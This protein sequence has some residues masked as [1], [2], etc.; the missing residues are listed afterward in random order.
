MPGLRLIA[1]NRMEDLVERLAEILATPLASPLEKEI[2]LVQS[3]GMERWVSMELARRHGVCANIRF[4][5]PNAFL[6]ET[7]SRVLGADQDSSFYE[8][9]AMTWMIMK[10]LRS[11]VGPPQFES[12]GNYL[13]ND[14][15]QLKR[16]QLARRI[17][18]LFDQYL[19]FRPEMT[20]AWENGREDHWQALLWREL[21]RGAN[22]VHRAALKRAFLEK[23]RDSSTEMEGFPD[24]LCIFG[25]SALPP[26][27]LEVIT[28]LSRFIRVNLFLM[29]PCQEYWG[30]IASDREIGRV[31]KKSEAKGLTPEQLHLE[32][33]NS[34]LAS[35]GTLGRDF[36]SLI[37]DK[38]WEEEEFF[39]DPGE[40]SLLACIQ[41]DILHL[42]EREPGS[43]TPISPEDRSIVVHSCHSPMREIEVL[44]DNLLALF[45]KQPELNPRDILV[46]TPDISSYAPF[47]QAVFDAPEKPS[48]RIPFSLADRSIRGESKILAV[49]LAILALSG[50]RFGASRVLAILEADAVRRKFGFSE[51]DLDAVRRWVDDT[52]IRWGIDGAHRAALGFPEFPENSWRA[53]L[54]R[55][56][57]GFA[58]P[59]GGGKLFRS[60]LPYDN[61]EGA[62]TVILGKF[63]E[64]TSR[65]FS[66][67]NE[68]E[69]PRTLAQWSATLT[70]LLDDF[71]QPEP[72][73][74]REVLML[75]QSLADLAARQELSGFDETVTLGVIRSHL[76]QQLESGS[77][78]PGF[79]TGG[80]TFCAM[81][82]MRAIPFQVI[83][84]VGMDDG[85]FPRQTHPLGFDLMARNPQRGDRS[86]RNDDRYLFLETLLSARRQL[87]IS[88][89]GQSI[90]DNSPMPPS[91][92][93]S[94]LLDVIESGFTLAG[95]GSILEHITTQHRLQPFSAQYFRAGPNQEERKYFSFSEEN[96]HAGRSMQST[97]ES[98]GPFL[99]LPLGEPEPEWRNLTIDQLCSF[100]AN[101][102]RFL[103]RKRL[104]VE[105]APA[106]DIA[107]DLEHFDLDRLE[108]YPIRQRL[109]EE[110]IAGHDPERLLVSER[111]AGRLPQG[112][113]GESRFALLHREVEDFFSKIEPYVREPLLPPREVQLDLA[114]FQLTGR[115]ERCTPLGLVHYRSAT[116]KARDRLA[117]WL[118][119]LTLN[120]LEEFQ[121]PRE[122]LLIGTDATVRLVPVR[123]ARECLAELL[124][125]YWTG[126][127]RPLHFFPE[128]SH[129]YAQPV[130]VHQQ[131]EQQALRKAREI[132][133]GTWHRNGEGG[134]EHYHLCFRNVDPIDAEFQRLSLAIYRPLIVHEVP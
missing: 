83:C 64:Y 58:M 115:I 16:Y 116:V 51:S 22:G 119:H 33:G 29:N 9:A 21:G 102:A 23:V 40:N 59:G 131:A 34:L 53:G 56:L 38:S 13:E 60:I 84:L 120:S 50:S 99:R 69:R 81:L 5:F 101:P 91:V 24:R 73:A 65:L 132:W 86:Q 48:A 76:V 74:E 62:D 96:F 122:S 31:V 19:I 57:L 109:L 93:V 108:Q 47:I 88:Y 66:R 80:V 121:G 98:P 112:R 45:A 114:P 87:T 134:E 25:I 27:H 30:H 10:L 68:L 111:A 6:Q 32:P 78:G 129:A 8:P 7:F 77:H 125:I 43:T 41:S 110:R 11:C 61:I 71:L 44:Y 49:F 95:P 104:Q 124:D 126:L 18:G 85:V 4:P 70:R 67:V 46:M 17:A 90:D 39:R 133:E 2:I 3:K 1:S 79:M 36:F 128:S 35:M 127:Q 118:W 37:H 72:D 103:L 20:L 75:R 28:E 97:G 82:P 92:L 55:L 89:V 105:L 42:R 107:E 63:L 123:Q 130:L 15:D 26:F 54:D 14:P 94:E 100:F 106:G 52:R 117:L 12:L 113:V